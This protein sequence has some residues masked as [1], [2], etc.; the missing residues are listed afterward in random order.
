MRWLKA[1]IHAVLQRLENLFH[2]LGGPK[3]NPLTQLGALGW[4]LF[5]VITASGIYLYAFFDTGVT[6]AY[7]SI[8]SITHDQWWAG[9]IMR[10]LHRYASDALVVVAFLHLL[11]EFGMDRM[12]GPRWFAWV[13]G[14]LLIGFTYVCGLTG[15]WMVWDQLAQYVALTTSQ[16]LDVLPIFAE[17]L[18]RNF[19]DNAGLSG[20]FFTL[21]VYM[22]I[23][24]PLIMLLFMWIHIQRY[25]F[26]R[27]NPERELMIGA[28]VVLVALS[29]VSPALSQ[30]PANLDQLAASVGL[31]WFYLAFYALIDRIGAPGLWGLVLGMLAALVV[32]PWLPPLRAAAPAAV[33]LDNCN[34]CARCF[35]DCPYS[36]ITMRPR[37][38]GAP[39]MEEASI[40][41]D[42]CVRCGICVGACP[43]ATPFRRASD[44]VAGVELPDT[45]VAALRRQVEQVAATLP[46]DGPRVL[47]FR[48]GHG[49]P[50]EPV[51]GAQVGVVEVPC[52]GMLPPPFVDFVLSRRLADGVTLGGCRE[53][54]CYNRLGLRWAEQ[55]IAGQRDPYLRDRVPRARLALSWA[56]PL[57]RANRRRDLAGF[58][59]ALSRPQPDAA[60]PAP[61]GP[62]RGLPA[63]LPG[64]VRYLLLA[65]I[66]AAAAGLLGFLSDT[67][68]V[69]L[70]GE[71]DAVVT[72][73]YSHPGRHL[74]ECRRPGA[75]EL[76]RLEPNMRRATQCPRGR[77]PVYLELELNGQLV[78]AG[79]RQPSGLWDDGPSSLFQRFA[80]PAGPQTARV[81][82]RDSGRQ[83]GFD[84]TASAELDLQPGQN[85]VIEFRQPDGFRIR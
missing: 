29:L 69:R 32:L 58:A 10:S 83:D 17:P 57:Q 34:G 6:Q 38:D 81:S 54:D 2:R 59:A 72:L 70:R 71:Q 66:A 13:T 51:P 78:Y 75:E 80:V 14:L 11:R 24:V 53:G 61:A 8:E 85:L 60:S 22:H 44:L 49:A 67:P 30:A 82:L 9:G 76:S 33:N 23:A 36:A 35:A 63:V 55:R 5:W 27:V 31:D 26:A 48:C 84:Y 45:S 3:G 20:R 73:S 52:T 74:Q 77:W 1:P 43:T 7:S 50:V 25:N 12:R 16:W 39:F 46:G 68:A 15:Y 79:E 62:W 28:T 41:P 18:S 42:L 65:G 47:V 56:G 21:M 64:V 40:D 19:I 37:S 4:Y